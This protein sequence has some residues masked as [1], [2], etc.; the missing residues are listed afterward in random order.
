MLALDGVQDPGNLGTLLRTAVAFGWSAVAL[1]PGCC[2]PFN[3]KAVR[4]S[5]GA[6]FQVPLLEVSWPELRA[7]QASQ[8]LSLLA[9]DPRAGERSLA[10]A[11]TALGPRTS[12]WLVLGSEGQA[13]EA[14]PLPPARPPPCLPAACRTELAALRRRA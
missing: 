2:D 11:S 7:L 1:M 13:R 4:A 10:A 14:L 5:K 12:C 6:C 3:D 9:A 8:G